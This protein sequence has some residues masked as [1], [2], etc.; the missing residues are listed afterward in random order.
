MAYPNTNTINESG[1]GSYQLDNS[2][3][4]GTFSNGVQTAYGVPQYSRMKFS[5]VADSSQAQKPTLLLCG[6]TDRADAVMLQA[7]N[8]GGGVSGV[9]GDFVQCRLTNAPGENYGLVNFTSTTPGAPVYE[10]ANG[11]LAS[12]GTILVGKTTQPVYGASGAVVPCTFYPAID[13]QSS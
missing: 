6:T 4:A 11:V 1:V 5:T 3:A 12:S 2:L 7:G 8:G 13:A 10:G 9:Q